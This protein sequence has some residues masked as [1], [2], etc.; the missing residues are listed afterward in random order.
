MP[1]RYFNWKLAIVIFVGLLVFGTTVFTL[2]RWQIS[3]R[4]ENALEVGLKA[5]EQKNWPLAASKLGSFLIINHDNVPI[6]LKYA[7]AQLKIRPSKRNNLQQAISAYRS[8]LRIA[9]NHPEAAERLIEL[10]LS[11]KLPSEAQLEAERF[12]G[13]NIDSQI[14]PNSR[15]QI[16]Q[17]PKIRRLLA[18]ALARQNQINKAV[19]EL[20][21]IIEDHPELVPAYETLAQITE[22][23]PNASEQSAKH[24]FDQAIK[25]DS[26]SAQAYIARAEFYFRAN[27]RSQAIADLEQAE[28]LDL[29][30]IALRLR[31]AGVYIKA[32]MLDE[33]QSQLIEA[34]KTDSSNQLLWVLWT[35][36]ALKSQDQTQ[37]VQIAKTGI[38]ELEFAP[39]DFML[40]AAELFIRGDRLDLAQDCIRK[41]SEN[42]IKPASV[43][44]LRG[45]LANQLNQGFEAVKYWQQSLKLGNKS[46]LIRLAI[47]QTLRTLGDNQTAKRQ[48][49]LLISQCPPEIEG[50]KTFHIRGQLELARLF[51]RQGDWA[52]SQ[53]HARIV[54][55]LSPNNLDGVLLHIQA[56]LRLEKNEPELMAIKTQLDNLD[57]AS[58][59][60]LEVKLTQFQLAIMQND[61]NNAEK[62]INQLKND[63]PSNMQVIMAQARM[64]ANVGNTKEAVTLLTDTIETLP[65]AIEPVEYL[66]LIMFQQGEPDKSE[67]LIRDA[68][69]RIKEPLA[70]RRLGLLLVDLYSRRQKPDNAYD[71]LTSLSG[72]MPND[73][74]IKRRLLRYQQVAS[75]TQKAQEIID[76]IKAIEGDDG[77]QWRYEQARLWFGEDFEIQ[78]TQIVSLLEENLLADPDNQQSRK[79]LAGAYA[80]AN[81]LRL[82][83]SI[84]REAFHRSPDDLSIMIPY[85]SLLNKEQLFEEADEVLNIAAEQKLYHP[86]LQAFRLQSYLRDEDID[87]AEKVLSELSTTDPNNISVSLALASMKIRK[88]QFDQADE[89]LKQLMIREPNSLAVAAV[90]IQSKIN[91]EK[92]DQAIRICD[93]VVK[94]SSTAMAYILRANT[95]ARLDRN[96]RAIED[97][98]RAIEAEPQNPQVWLTKSRY[99]GSSDIDQAIELVEK[100]Q[101]LAP[102]DLNIC[103]QAI[104]FFIASGKRE[105]IR[106][107]QTRLNDALTKD[108]NDV[109]LRMLKA[110]LLVRQ[111]TAPADAQAIAVLNKITEDK[112]RL[113]NA[114]LLMGNLLLRQGN[115]DKAI[116]TA[117][118]G[119]SYIH[120]NRALLLFKARAE[121][122]RTPDVA[123]ATLR[124]LM[125]RYSGDIEIVL[126][127]A[128][129]YAATGRYEK[130][131]L[132][133][134]NQLPNFDSN[135]ADKQKIQIQIAVMIYKSGRKND[136]EK[137]F[138]TLI[139]SAPD[140]P[141]PFL[142]QARV[143]SDDDMWDKL[144]EC[145]DKWQHNH[146]NDTQTLVTVARYFSSSSD[147]QA[148]TNAELYLRAILERNSRD[149]AAMNYLAMLLQ[150]NKRFTESAD[151]YRKILSDNPQNVIAAN[152]L[153]WILCKNQN[154]YEPALKLVNSALEIAPNYVDLIDTRGVIYHQLGRFKEAI[155]DFEKC[156]ELYRNQ[157][158]AKTAS[159]FHLALSLEGNQQIQKAAEHAKTALSLNAKV[160]GLSP[161]EIAEANRIVNV[162]ERNN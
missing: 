19:A 93:E 122:D 32:D 132:M 79:L 114:W 69:E 150:R 119:L 12:L 121:Q 58:G 155:I 117:M 22:Q 107:A 2:R 148:Q 18:I 17:E 44:F 60:A 72:Q 55:L 116:S 24:W 135:H 52:Q 10:Y 9:R 85:L 126:R 50:L 125:E 97:L 3:Q 91:Q 5:Y 140:D 68:L 63:N 158:P 25:N 30:D 149:V 136:A 145:T 151:L 147:E 41:L 43:A 101:S 39:W 123:V 64:I 23:N 40:K 95:Y 21:A 42:D 81:Q 49:Q 76:Q 59:G 62:M 108:P 34:K 94:K 131:L 36:F 37:M 124:G 137:I 33:T 56:R 162:S 28:K 156:L 16:S 70:Q 73:V 133:L 27:N 4:A 51:A 100:A 20:T 141:V 86:K 106:Q 80:R 115:W 129:A 61:T 105:N 84:Y 35:Q 75:N 71:L 142:V 144:K 109:G 6:L 7:D 113:Q 92:P 160:G 47:A 98:D 1:K 14:D 89:L 48:L 66:A 103:K 74:T 67:T 65:Q 88:K 53:N 134:E 104:K 154:Q 46:P 139:N 11:L 13:R 99:F 90:L 8:I 45:L 118:R 54:T 78:S 157:T 77:W 146:P 111:G 57:K 15:P 110:R 87:Q 152:N 102:D 130:G 120:N 38:K 138:E 153:A 127:L 161:T 159:H 143:L 29:S 31:L 83:I 96:E 26:S 112:P 82:A 128:D